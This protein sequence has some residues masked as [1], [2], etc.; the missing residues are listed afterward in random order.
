MNDPYW[1]EKGHLTTGLE[2]KTAIVQGIG[3]VGYYFAK[4]FVEDG[5]GI[6]TGMIE[7]NGAIYDES[8]IDVNELK[9]FFAQNGTFRGYPKGEFFENPNAVFTK[10]C[11]I[12]VPAAIEQTVHKKNA[13]HL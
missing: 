9:S 13:F 3:N 4:F 1:A 7:H 12:L 8:G 5:N 6:V 10:A 2:G 11:D